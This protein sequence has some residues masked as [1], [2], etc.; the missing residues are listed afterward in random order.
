MLFQVRTKKTFFLLCLL[1]GAFF[2]CLIMPV[3][4]S[5]NHSAEPALASAPFFWLFFGVGACILI[6][7]ISNWLA[8]IGLTKE[9]KHDVQ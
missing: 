5:E 3:L 6:V 8:Q 4:S 2:A 1:A 9:E 7:C